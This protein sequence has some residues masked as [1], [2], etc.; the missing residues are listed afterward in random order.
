MAADFDANIT[1]N[2]ISFLASEQNKR[3]GELESQA[4]VSTGYIARTRESNAKPGVEFVLRIADALNISVD[5]LLKVDLATLTPTEQY[6][7]KFLGKLISDTDGDKLDWK[8]E[9]DSYLRD[10][11]PDMNGNYL[12]PL[13]NEYTVYEGNTEDAPAHHVVTFDSNSFGLNTNFNGNSYNLRLK[14]GTILYLMNVCIFDEKY[15]PLKTATEVWMY[16]YNGDCHSAEF[17]CSTNSRDEISK[18]VRELNASVSENVKHPKI[19]KGLRYVI[20]SYMADDIDDDP[21]SDL[22]F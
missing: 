21:G 18:M 13:I 8:I 15:K 4:G 14:N 2:N 7:V 22:P 11:E 19:N 17:L 6:I 9:S 1:F 3:I 10:M 20:D 12:H 5:T 16:G